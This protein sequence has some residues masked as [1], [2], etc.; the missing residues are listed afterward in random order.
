MTSH[1]QKK[2][3]KRGS[4][5]WKTEEI[6]PNAARELFHLRLDCARASLFLDLSTWHHW[7]HCEVRIGSKMWQSRSIR[8]LLVKI[9]GEYTWCEFSSGWS[10]EAALTLSESSN[11]QEIQCQFGWFN[12]RSWEFNIK[13]CGWY[14]AISFQHAD[15]HAKLV[16]YTISGKVRSSLPVRHCL[17]GVSLPCQTQLGRSVG[18]SENGWVFPQNGN[19]FII[20]IGENI[21]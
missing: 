4:F 20:F 12:Y 18:L 14:H 13:Y 9:F 15:C 8:R 2:K 10:T 7:W 1:E 21:G 17:D 11:A 19:V 16:S 6:H 5:T 3:L